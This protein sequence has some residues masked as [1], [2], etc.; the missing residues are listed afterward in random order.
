[1]CTRLILLMG[2][3]LGTSDVSPGLELYVSSVGSDANEGTA[4]SPLATLIGARDRIRTLRQENRHARETVA[5]VWIASGTYELANGVRL[6]AEDSNV[7]YKAAKGS[8]VRL[9]G[10]RQIPHHAFRAVLDPMV[11]NRLPSAAARENVREVDLKSLGIANYGQLQ[12]YGHMLPVVTAPLELFLDGEPLP[13]SR[14]PNNDCIEL[15]E[16]IDPGSIPREGDYSQRGGVFKY[17]DP[18]HSRWADAEDVWVQGTLHYGYADD[19][20]RIESIDVRKQHVKLAGEHLYGLAAGRPYQ[21]YFVYN[22]LEELDAPG[23]WYLD[24]SV[25]LL[26]LW[27]PKDLAAADLAVSLVDEPLVSLEEAS[28]VTL[29]GLVIEVG[30]GI[31]VYIEGGEN[32]VVRQCTVRNVGNTGVLMGVGA[33]QTFPYITHDD[34]EGEPVSREIGNLQAHQYK[35]TTWDRKAGRR[36]LIDS[37]E[38]YNTGAGGIFLSGGSKRELTPGESTVTNCSVHDYNRRNKFL[39]SGINVDGCGN[40]VSHCEIYGS[41]FQGIFVRGND[42]TFEY[43]YLHD[44]AMDSDDTSAWYVGRDPSDRGNVIKHNFFANIGRSDRMVMGIYLD[45]GACGVEVLG[46]VFYRCA[47]RGSVFSN[48][49]H[50]VKVVNNIFIESLGP[51]V[52]LNS[53]FYNISD[54]HRAHFFGTP[55]SRA[56]DEAS[57]LNETP[58]KPAQGLFERRLLE[59]LNIQ[60]APYSDRYP[61]LADYMD[62]LEDGVTRVGLRPRRNVMTRNVVVRCPE[63]LSLTALHA[64][65]AAGDNYITDDDPGFVDAQQQDFTLRDDSAVYRV[66]GEF[67]PI[68]FRRIGRRTSEVE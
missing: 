64:Q 3:L 27:P 55:P 32:N 9:I 25:G 48:S 59:L 47:S 29:E 63:A 2:V 24:R 50:D 33:R 8:V 16:I 13:L 43:N 36:H 56:D 40:T 66:I 62:Y 30:R 65:F 39:W 7:A 4:T 67:E 58:R 28:H 52:A 20:I 51:A 15:R 49:G 45:D 42:H 21:K 57:V 12:R 19:N 37:C 35:F 68:P 54:Q 14:Y 38:I 5:T 6:T 61:E 60:A 10:G 11:L 46:N 41:D 22:L 34:Y 23:E 17:A 53:I 31:G 44:L 1:M 18:R 26:Y